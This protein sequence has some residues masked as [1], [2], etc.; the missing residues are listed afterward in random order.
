MEFS[1]DQLAG[2]AGDLL[3]GASRSPLL[4][5]RAL[6]SLTALQAFERTASHL[7]FRRAAR[8]LALTPSAISHQIRNLE[9]HFGVRLFSRDGRTVRLTPEGAAYL[10]AVSRSLALLDEASRG[11]MQEGRGARR[12][13]RVSALPIF[14]STVMIPWLTAFEQQHPHVTL[15]V[16]GTHDYADFDRHDVD[17][18]LRLG[19]EQSTGLRLEPVLELRNVPVAAPRLTS[20]RSLKPAELARRPLIHVTR[21]PQAWRDW[22]AAAGHAGP[23]GADEIWF[24]S[25]SEALD[26]AE[27]GFGVALAPSPLI[28]ARRGFGDTLVLAGEPSRQAEMLNLVMRP[29]HADSTWVIAFRRWLLDAVRRTTG[30]N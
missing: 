12:E 3:K 23:Q 10:D 4:P 14:M 27:H 13:I 1:I 15:R 5:L 29:P 7:S 18:A 20:G 24:D 17:L 8:D 2:P 6:P 9:D 21:Q 28:Q 25:L 22:F 11:L 30:P 19:R 26:A 16:Q